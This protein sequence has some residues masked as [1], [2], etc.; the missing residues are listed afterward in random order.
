M[1]QTDQ[2]LRLEGVNCYGSMTQPQRTIRVTLD[3]KSVEIDADL[4]KQMLDAA[5]AEALGHY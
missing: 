5:D 2:R 1:S 4:L 3:D